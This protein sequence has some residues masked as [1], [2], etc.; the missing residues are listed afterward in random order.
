VLVVNALQQLLNSGFKSGG[1]GFKLNL[2]GL[3]RRA[4]MGRARLKLSD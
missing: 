2:N 4:D 3:L 1:P